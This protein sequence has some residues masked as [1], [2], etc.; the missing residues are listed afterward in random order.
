MERDRKE[1]VRRREMKGDCTSDKSGLIEIS[2]GT[3]AQCYRQEARKMAQTGKARAG[4]LHWWREKRL[5]YFHTFIITGTHATHLPGGN[6]PGE[7]RD[8]VL[9]AV[10]VREMQ[11]PG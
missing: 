10:S 11:H 3:A 9:A 4:I 2:A 7:T 6:I 8:A 5:D 1:R